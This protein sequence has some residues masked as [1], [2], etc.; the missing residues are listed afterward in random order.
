MGKAIKPTAQQTKLKPAKI[1]LSKEQ[2]IRA[3]QMIRLENRISVCREYIRLWSKLFELFADDI[4]KRQITEQEEKAFFQTVT[5][6]ARKHFLFCELLSDTFDA[7]DKIMDVLVNA[8]A[9]SNIKAMNEATLSK[10]ELDWHQLFLEMNVA[11]GRLLRRLP[12][13]TKLDDALAKADAMAQQANQEQRAAAVAPQ[14]TGAPAQ[15]R[16]FLSFLFR[17][18]RA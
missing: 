6:L 11:L 15:K 17:K 12:A 13:G 10:L 14:P 3:A 2:K 16:G 9:L 4:Q 18:G 5:A 8:V 7:G 1:K